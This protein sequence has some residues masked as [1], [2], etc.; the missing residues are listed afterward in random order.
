MPLSAHVAIL[1]P[2]KHQKLVAV[3]VRPNDQDC[4]EIGVLHE[5]INPQGNRFWS[6]MQEPAFL[7]SGRQRRRSC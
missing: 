7:G 6:S 3:A 5:N 4:D 1:R 2:P